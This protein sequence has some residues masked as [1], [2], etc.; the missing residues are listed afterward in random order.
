MLATFIAISH[1]SIA[2]PLAIDWWNNRITLANNL[3]GIVGHKVHW[4]EYAIHIPSN[5]ELED[6]RATVANRPDH[7][8]RE[9]LQL[10]DKRQ[11][12]PQ[13]THYV[14]FVL[15]PDKWRIESGPDLDSIQKFS[16]RNS[17]TAFE[18]TGA[19][20]TILD[21][22]IPY[23][24][25]QEY[26]LK[27]TSLFGAKLLIYQAAG[28]PVLSKT[29]GVDPEIQVFGNS[30]ELTYVHKASGETWMISLVK[31]TLDDTPYT[32]DYYQ[33]SGRNNTNVFQFNGHQQITDNLK[34]VC[35]IVEWQDGKFEKS[36]VYELVDISP[37][38][39][40]SSIPLSIPQKSELPPLPENFPADPILPIIRD[41]RKA[42]GHADGTVLVVNP[43][44]DIPEERVVT[45]TQTQG[46][47]ASSSSVRFLMLASGIVLLIVSLGFTVAVKAIRK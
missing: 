16:V 28:I 27:G 33:H 35:K 39:D 41:F 42:N 21:R 11:G 9:L 1:I 34:S 5:E 47:Q 12:N 29:S 23:P 8:S 38:E 3:E 26:L 17:D 40:S 43:D 20:L 31:S 2:D 24:E 10:A 4:I 14:A 45:I 7:P 32:I 22:S 36:K 18:A 13:I 25:S 46:D 37:I 6:I 30:V 19:A 44:S 15:A